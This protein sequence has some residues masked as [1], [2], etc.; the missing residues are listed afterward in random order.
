[1]P[2]LFQRG[3]GV[4]VHNKLDMCLSITDA[5]GGNE[6]KYGKNLC[7]IFLT[8]PDPQ[9]HVM[10]VKCQEPIHFV[11]ELIVQ[12]WLLYHQPNF[13]YCTLFASGMELQTD[14]QMD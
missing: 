8:P 5:P 14:K 6:V 9:G 3:L 11:D 10:S 13:K 12:V 2:L 7:P 1:M 4:G